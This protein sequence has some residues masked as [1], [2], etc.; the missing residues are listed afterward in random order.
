MSR[1]RRISCDDDLQVRMMIKQ[2]GAAGA[3]EGGEKPY[4]ACR[5]VSLLVNVGEDG[6]DTRQQTKI[7][8][9]EWPVDKGCFADDVLARHKSPLTGVGTVASVV[10]HHKVLVRTYN[11]FIDGRKR[12]GWVIFID[13]WFV[14]R[15]PINGDSLSH[16][17]DSVTGNSDDALH[18]V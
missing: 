6:H 18:V 16:D 2:R 11:A 5:M 13:V 17:T 10:S 9:A 7:V 12:V 14:Q 4:A 1:W 15:Y 8:F 3:I